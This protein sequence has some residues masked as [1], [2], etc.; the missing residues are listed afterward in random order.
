MRKL[1]HDQVFFVVVNKQDFDKNFSDCNKNNTLRSSLES[2]EKQTNS[3][4]IGTELQSQ[5]F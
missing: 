1:P 3:L 4:K 2:S 5:N